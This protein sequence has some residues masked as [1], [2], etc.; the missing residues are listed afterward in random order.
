[1]QSLYPDVTPIPHLTVAEAETLCLIAR[2]E[3]QELVGHATGR[4]IHTVHNHIIRIYEKLTVQSA[5]SAV[6]QAFRFGI[7]A[8]DAAGEVTIAPDWWR[9]AGRDGP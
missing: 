9:Y 8:V 1:M 3:T 6:A 2:G 5:A 4:S 7:L